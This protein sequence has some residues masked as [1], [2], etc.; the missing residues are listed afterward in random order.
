[1][2]CPNMTCFVGQTCRCRAIAFRTRMATLCV[3]A[4][5]PFRSRRASDSSAQ[6]LSF[7]VPRA[8][9]MAPRWNF[10]A[11]RWNFGVP[12]RISNTR[13]RQIGHSDLGEHLTAAPKNSLFASRGRFLGRRGGIFVHR[14]GIC[15]FCELYL[16]FWELCYCVLATVLVCF[17]N[18]FVVF[19][20]LY[21]GMCRA[22]E[23]I[24]TN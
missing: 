10:G 13:A 2:T 1:M 11:P 14:G 20:E 16:V 9:F 12:M 7:C 22:W 5:W 4:E 21:C 19:W 3:A 17:G 8:L 24:L 18:C 15:V 23:A 6:T